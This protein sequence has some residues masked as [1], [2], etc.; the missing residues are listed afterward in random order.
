MGK[1]KHEHER[2]VE[3]DHGARSGGAL[4]VAVGTRSLPDR[5]FQER[6]ATME[7]SG[8]M[9]REHAEMAAWRE[10]RI[11]TAGVAGEKP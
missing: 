3:V 8:G 6:A 4:G 5:A 9:A 2:Q 7:F 11:M 10:V 1:R